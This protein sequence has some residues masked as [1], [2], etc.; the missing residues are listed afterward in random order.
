MSSGGLSDSDAARPYGREFAG[1][2]ASGRRPGEAAAI[3]VVDDSP[4]NVRLYSFLLR[5]L[6][7]EIVVAGSGI[8]ALK[9]AATRE[10]AMVLLDVNLQDMIGFEVARCLRSEL[11]GEHVPIVFISAAFTREGDQFEGYE[12]GAVDY[13]LSPV[14]P[15]IL[16][17]K[18]RVFLDLYRLRQELQGRITQLE[19]VT[20]ALQVACGEMD[21]FTR[22]VTQDLE[23]PLG[24]ISGF[25]EA[26]LDE[27][28][29]ALDADGRANLRSIAR[30]VQRMEMLVGDLF[31]LR[32]ADFTALKR[33]RV[34]LTAQAEEILALLGRSTPAQ[35][36]ECR[37]QPG[38]QAEGDAA[39]LHILL[40]HLLDH[41]WK[42]CLGLRHPF[43]E[44]VR[45]EVDGEAEFSLRFGEQPPAADGEA[46]APGLYLGLA[47]VRK[48]IAHHGGR[49]RLDTPQP[50]VNAIRFTLRGGG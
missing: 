39:M 5:D 44:F 17:A 36:I 50:G 1:S 19:Q 26:L 32:Q 41:A 43:I 28:A 38:L 13:L 40:A 23:V 30:C 45:D 31:N 47:T 2:L 12:A 35:Q 20:R 29:V 37:I 16:R 6:G 27:H 14:D 21:A 22:A 10:F 46:G 4:A 42:S 3:L 49:I 48:I 24:H 25:A 33:S 8:E 7:A 15:E 11:P 34:D 9:A 18:A